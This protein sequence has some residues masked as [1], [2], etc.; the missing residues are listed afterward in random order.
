MKLVVIELGASPISQKLNTGTKPVFVEAIRPHLYR[1][2]FAAGTLQML[3]YDST[4]TTL[5]ASSQTLNIS[6]LDSGFAYSHGYYTFNVNVGLAANTTY[7]FQLVGAGGYTFSES[8]YV[9]WVNGLDLGKYPATTT[10]TDAFHY[11]LDIEVWN[12]SQV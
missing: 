4:G 11:P 1:H 3:V 6:A 12:R 8:A 10:P 9:G 5:V 2:N 7:T